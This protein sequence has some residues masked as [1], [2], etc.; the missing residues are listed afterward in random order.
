MMT[1]FHGPDKRVHDAVVKERVRHQARLASDAMEHRR[2]A[3]ETTALRNTAAK[4]IQVCLCCL[5]LF[6]FCVQ[7]SLRYAESDMLV[8]KLYTSISHRVSSFS[9]FHNQQRFYA[10]RKGVR[11]F[12]AFMSSVRQSLKTKLAK[13]GNISL[14]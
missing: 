7:R 10:N 13:R 9:V 4:K 2:Q 3:R 11:V 5:F 6:S 1:H 12:N 8:F 14:M